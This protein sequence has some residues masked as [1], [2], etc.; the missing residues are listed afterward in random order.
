MLEIDLV[1]NNFG[2]PGSLKPTEKA[3]LKLP[4]S[5]GSNESGKALLLVEGF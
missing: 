3:I 4:V 2:N 5:V 1:G